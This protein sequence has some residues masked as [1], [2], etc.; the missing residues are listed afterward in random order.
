MKTNF[1]VIDT[2]ALILLIIAGLDLGLIG[3][4]EWKF[5]AA[6]FGD[7]TTLTRTIY[8]LTGL[9]ALFKVVVFSKMARPR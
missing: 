9:A 4:F 7:E 3:L 1:Q 6:I 5:I 8:S 2:I